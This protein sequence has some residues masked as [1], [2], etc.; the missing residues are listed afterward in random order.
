M[1]CRPVVNNTSV[2][3]LSAFLNTECTLHLMD[4][5]IC[6]CDIYHIYYSTYCTDLTAFTHRRLS[7]SHLSCILWYNYAIWEE[8]KDWTRVVKCFATPCDRSQPT[9]HFQEPPAKGQQQRKR[10]KSENR[11]RPK[12]M[13]SPFLLVDV[14]VCMDELQ[15]G[16][17]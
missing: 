12:S 16:V 9:L 2:V 6:M 8:R 17:V 7:E 13:V 4:M 5:V 15:C 11:P 10:G 3:N 1:N 14:D